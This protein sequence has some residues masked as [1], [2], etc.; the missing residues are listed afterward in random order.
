MHV[1][2]AVWN[3]PRQNNYNPIRGHVIPLPHVK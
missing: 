3:K 2:E 1:K